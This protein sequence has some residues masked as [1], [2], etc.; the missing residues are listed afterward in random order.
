MFVSAALSAVP[1]CMYSLLYMHIRG[2]QNFHG[3]GFDENRPSVYIDAVPRETISNSIRE[4]RQEAGVTQ[5][6]IARLVGVTRLTIIAMEKGNYVP[7]V[8]L[9]LRCA[10]IF[11]CSVE[12]L[13]YVVKSR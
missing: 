10:K 3:K 5:E 4:H 12:D 7:S 13:F 9:A 1:E 2:K 6:E 8:L 11:K